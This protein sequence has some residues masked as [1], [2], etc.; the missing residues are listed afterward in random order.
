MFHARGGGFEPHSKL[1]L[2]DNIV[3]EVNADPLIRW[4]AAMWAV[5][6]VGVLK[7]VDYSERR[8][9]IKVEDTRDWRVYEA[10]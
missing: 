6:V 4:E 3:L 2:D 5:E 7:S 8:L 9:R 1:Q 10:R